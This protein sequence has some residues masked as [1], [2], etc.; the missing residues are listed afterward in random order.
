[1]SEISEPA[2]IE[3]LDHHPSDDDLESEILKGLSAP[4]KH[5]PPKFFYD[6]RGSELFDAICELPEYYP[7]RTEQQIMADTIDEIVELIGPKASLIEFGSGA[8]IK[9]RILLSHLP[10][11]AAYV[12]VDISK[13]HLL[14]AA[15][16]LQKDYP[17]VAIHPV[18]ADFTKPFAL[19]NPAIKPQKNIV[20]FPGSTI[21]NFDTPDAIN[22]LRVIRQI[23][24]VGGGLLIGVDLKK[25]T[26]VL[27]AAYN[28]SQG[29]TADFNMN[30]LIRMNREFDANFDL[31]AFTH[32]A[33][34]VESEGRIEMHLVS[35]KDQTVEVAGQSFHFDKGESIHTESSHKYHI[36]EFADM[37]GMAG[38]RVQHV[39][40][41][42]NQLFSVQ[43][44]V[45]SS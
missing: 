14:E 38:F 17:Q 4:Q 31:S 11:L 8:S 36:P 6:K 13:S 22:L 28:D 3:L 18:C 19:P 42:P 44:L 37:A 9:T 20:Y 5:L 41:D 30:M 24:G 7:T 33:P 27:E 26:T 32:A 29:V 23:A 10:E 12:P 21:G 16:S 45:S 39:W 43:L 40:T 35:Q 2:A 34:Y 15:R 1:M 25:D